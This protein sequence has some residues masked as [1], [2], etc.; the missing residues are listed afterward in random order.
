MENTESRTK[1]GEEDGLSQSGRDFLGRL[2]ETGGVDICEL[3][4]L[5][6]VAELLS[7]GKVRVE[8]TAYAWGVSLRVVP[9]VPRMTGVRARGG[10]SGAATRA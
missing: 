1:W 3:G 9:A 5:E 6:G 10:M 4:S 2:T 8:V 7:A